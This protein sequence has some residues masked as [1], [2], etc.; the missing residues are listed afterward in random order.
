LKI[1][2]NLED[3]KQDL[4]KAWVDSRIAFS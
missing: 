4:I 2:L 3:T 1:F